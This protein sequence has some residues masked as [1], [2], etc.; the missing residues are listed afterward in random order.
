MKVILLE[1]DT[2]KEVRDGYARNYLFPKKLA[3]AATAAAVVQMEKRRQKKSAE[4][5]QQETEA[6]DRA[7]QI[8]E[9]SVSILS[10]AGEKDKLFGSIGA[11]EISE[12]L[13]EQ[14]QIEIDRK[15]IVLPEPIKVLGE[16]IVPI[17]LFHGIVAKLKVVVEKK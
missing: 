7:K 4:V 17:K 12:A 13:K 10:P 9:I 2:I 5:E 8:S 6:R 14:R 15:K 3:I 16:F 11:K 1:D